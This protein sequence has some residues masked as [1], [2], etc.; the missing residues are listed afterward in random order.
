MQTS[1]QTQPNFISCMAM[2]G[3][4][5]SCFQDIRDVNDK[6]DNKVLVLFVVVSIV[7]YVQLPQYPS[8]F[9]WLYTTLSFSL[10]ASQCLDQILN[11][12]YLVYMSKRFLKYFSTSLLSASLV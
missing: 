6:K 1:P 9:P 7:G 8:L 5:L 3:G 12:T 10:N 11:I 2:G 4:G